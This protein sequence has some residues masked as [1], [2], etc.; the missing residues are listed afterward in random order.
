MAKASED[1]QGLNNS[2]NRT[3]KE[4]ARKLHK[5]RSPVSKN[6]QSVINWLN[7]LSKLLTVISMALKLLKLF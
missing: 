1:F 5:K 2:S 6:G 4:S 3:K 7:L